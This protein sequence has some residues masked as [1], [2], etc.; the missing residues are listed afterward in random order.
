MMQNLFELAFICFIPYL[1]P[2]YILKIEGI[3]FWQSW[4]YECFPFSVSG[5]HFGKH[6]PFKYQLKYRNRKQKEH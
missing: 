4:I 3:T 1:P 6:L 5:Y 2:R